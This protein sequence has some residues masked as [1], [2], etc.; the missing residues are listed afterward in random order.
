MIGPRKRWAAVGACLAVVA[1]MTG[2]ES[3]EG[4]VVD[5]SGY[6]GP[7][8]GGVAD[9]ICI[10]TTGDRTRMREI[11]VSKAVENAVEPG[12]PCPVGQGVR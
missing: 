2:C 4:W 12:D 6:H 7:R 3:N 5:Y 1:V 11:N 8:G 9:V 10:P